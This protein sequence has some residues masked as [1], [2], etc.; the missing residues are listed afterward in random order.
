MQR[1]KIRPGTIILLIL[2][3]VVAISGVIW[4]GK[5]LLT[6]S[7]QSTNRP[8]A[9]QNLL[10]NPTAETSVTMTARGPIV[11][12]E[13]HYSISLT[14]TKSSRSLTV[15][16]GYNQA[17][18]FKRVDLNNDEAA[19]KDLLLALNNNGML[20]SKTSGIAKNDSLCSDGQLIEF[21]VGNGNKN[22]T[23]LWTTSCGSVSGNFGGDRAKIVDLLMNQI[24]D[25]KSII[26]AARRDIEK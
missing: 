3:A 1:A 23:S 16:K 15:Y 12:R 26:S 24:P 4:L 19:F 25:S 20:A 5:N 6:V 7:D 11:A 9:T 2:L 10:T 13:H 14:I 17:E 21:S 8:Q 22:Q 18:T